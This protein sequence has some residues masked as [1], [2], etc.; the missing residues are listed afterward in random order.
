MT[1]CAAT[2]WRTN[3][4]MID[5]VVGLGNIRPDDAVIDLTFGLGNW[6]NSYR[7]PGRFVANINHPGSQPRLEPH[8]EQV[9]IDF[10]TPQ[11]DLAGVFDVT[12]FDPPYVSIGGRTTSSI[13]DFNDRFGLTTAGRTPQDVQQAI[14]DGLT[15]ATQITKPNGLIMVKCADYVSSGKLQH[16][17]WWTCEHAYRLGLSLH[18]KLIHV[19]TVRPQPSGRRI[20]HARQN[21]SYLFI[22]KVP[23]GRQPSPIA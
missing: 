20:V 10:T 2:S 11:P 1:I 22:F 16:G 5:D 17:T 23:R 4:H 6:W 21:L 14:N 12:V 8:W 7:H 13:P 19:G 9:A 18:D 3:S 15:V